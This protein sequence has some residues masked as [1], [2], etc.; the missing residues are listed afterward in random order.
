MKLIEIDLKTDTKVILKNWE[1]FN[2]LN[3]GHKISVNYIDDNSNHKYI[4]GIICSIEHIFNSDNYS[5]I[6]QD[7]YIKIY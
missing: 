2:N 7:T 3:I 5:P 1:R 4:N 6:T